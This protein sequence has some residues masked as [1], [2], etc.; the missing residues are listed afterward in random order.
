[1]VKSGCFLRLFQRCKDDV[2]SDDVFAQWEEAKR[3]TKI[4]KD[5]TWSKCTPQAP[6]LKIKKIP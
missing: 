2:T 1:M 6:F 5:A 3:R 4:S